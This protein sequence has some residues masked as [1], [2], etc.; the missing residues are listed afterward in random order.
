M[1]SLYFIVGLGLLITLSMTMRLKQRWQ[2]LTA[3]ERGLERQDAGLDLGVISMIICIMG[4]GLVMVY[5]ASFTKSNQEFG[6]PYHFLKRQGIFT[7]VGLLVMWG[8][9]KINY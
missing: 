6:D 1:T 3:L 7:V 2:R 9:S 8:V 5:S 4:I